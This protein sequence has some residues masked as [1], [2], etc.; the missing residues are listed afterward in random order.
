MNRWTQ[1]TLTRRE[2]PTLPSI[3]KNWWVTNGRIAVVGESGVI[4][5]PHLRLEQITRPAREG[6]PHRTDPTASRHPYG[7]VGSGHRLRTRAACR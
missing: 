2:L 6:V 4:D 5:Q 3:P 7:K 1:L